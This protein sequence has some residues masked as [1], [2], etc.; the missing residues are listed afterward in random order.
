MKKCDLEIKTPATVMGTVM[1]RTLWICKFF[2]YLTLYELHVHSFSL[3]SCL[4]FHEKCQLS[5]PTSK[6][7]KATAY[8]NTMTFKFGGLNKKKT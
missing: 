8:M 1:S 5:L 7:E 6:H 4:N 3:S 2:E